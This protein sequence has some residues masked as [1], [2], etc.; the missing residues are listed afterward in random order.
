MEGSFSIYRQ[1]TMVT[2]IYLVAKGESKDADYKQHTRT[3]EDL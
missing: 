1:D 2:C 3:F